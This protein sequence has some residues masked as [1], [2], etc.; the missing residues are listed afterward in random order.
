M[1]CI[2]TKR[3]RKRKSPWER[4]P[5]QIAAAEAVLRESRRLLRDPERLLQLL[6]EGRPVRLPLRTDLGVIASVFEAIH[7][8]DYESSP[9]RPDVEVL[10][11][12]LL[13]CRDETDL[14]TD[15]DA[16]RYANALL[17]L[18]AHHRDWLRPLEDWRAPSHNA[19]R[20]FHSLVRHLIARY[21]VPAFL[22]AAWLEGLTP[23]AVK[24]QGWFKHIASGQNI[25]TAGDLPIPL[26]KKQADSFLRA[27]DDFDIPSAFRWAVIIDLGGDERLVR[28]ILGTRV[29]TSFE[30]EEFCRAV[31]RFFVAHPMLDSAHHG[32]IVDFLFNQKFL[33]S[34][35]NPLAGQPGEPSMVPPQPNLCMKGRT[36]ESLL[37]AVREWHRSLSRSRAPAITEW[38]PSGFAPFIHEDRT[39]EGVRRYEIIELLTAQELI[40]EGREMQHCAASYAGSCASGRTSIWS[41]R[42]QI[43]TGR[44]IRMATVEVSNKQ[45]SIVQVRRRCNKLPT[46]GDL[47]ILQRW[48]EASGLRL[49]YWMTA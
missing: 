26:T 16:P 46:E 24:Y 17:A 40:D 38:E 12:L 8:G 34:V 7:R 2:Q 35:P 19:C 33:P 28:S 36:P 11:H 13:F 1:E 6:A 15:Q 23:E 49:A 45:R 39:A 44:L 20:Q 30:V 18:A 5:S 25:R 47:A 43:E 31:F 48:G 4:D 27:P 22:D 10:G 14:L 42:K 21:D 37:R 41:L 9:L 29:G 3:K 32:P